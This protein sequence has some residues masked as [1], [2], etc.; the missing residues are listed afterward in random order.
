MTTLLRAAD[1]AG[2]LRLIPSLAGFTPRQSIVLL[3]FRGT[4]THGALRLDPPDD[5]A[6]LG[7]YVDASVGLLTRIDGTDGV[8]L[9]AYSDEE[10]PH[11]ADGL[12]LPFSVTV[13]AL[14][15][16]AGDAGLRI[17]DAL[18][19]TPAGWSS[20]LDDVPR[21]GSLDEI[22]P[23]TDIPGVGDVSGDQHTG[24]Q[25][26]DVDAAEQE[27]VAGTLRDVA[28]LLDAGAHADPAGAQNTRA[29][30]ALVFLDDIPAFFESLLSAPED[31]SPPATAA[32]LWCLDRPLFRD[33][34][35]SQWATALDGG[36]RALDAQL[37]FADT[38][39]MLPDDL[40]DVFL[41]RGAAPDPDRLRRALSVVRLAA[42]KAPRASR[43]G[44]LTAAAWMSWALGLASHAG[45]YLDAVREIDPRYGLA[46]LLDSMIEAAVLPE[47]AFRRGAVR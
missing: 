20:Y 30:G 27:L 22:E 19:V 34:A 3:P 11:T 29:L 44:P 40:G 23:V 9:V 38:G 45:R 21:L 43:P 25:L 41:G 26:P 35:L 8:A 6:D 46:A 42:A 32:L 5:G 16:C 47:W 2:L 24:T 1:S 12:V 33:V 28:A 13:T 37:A 7:H 31:I 4:R 10:P 14:L 17:V 18:C 15:G 39:E 36:R